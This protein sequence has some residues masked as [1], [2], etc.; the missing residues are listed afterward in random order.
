MHDDSDITQVF[1]SDHGSC[2]TPPDNSGLPDLKHKLLEFGVY[3]DYERYRQKYCAWKD[4]AQSISIADLPSV[5]R[6]EDANIISDPADFQDPYKFQ[7]W[8]PTPQKFHFFFTTSFW[9]AIWNLQAAFLMTF[10]AARRYVPIDLSFDETCLSWID[11]MSTLLWTCSSYFTYLELINLPD[12]GK[13]NFVLPDSWQDV[14]DR[15]GLESFIGSIVPVVAM[16]IWSLGGIAE[17]VP[18]TANS[19]PVQMTDV[20]GGFGFAIVGICEIYHNRR[21]SLRQPFMWAAIVDFLGGWCLVAAAVQVFVASDNQVSQANSLIAGICFIVLAGLELVMWRGNDYGL[22]LLSQLNN[23]IKA[24]HDVAISP[25]T[26]RNVGLAFPPPS[27]QGAVGGDARQMLGSPLG[28]PRRLPQRQQPPPSP[29]ASNSAPVL[30]FSIRGCIFMIVYCWLSS[31]LVINVIR[32]IH[33]YTHTVRRLATVGM[34]VLWILIMGIVFLVHST[35]TSVPNVQPYRAAMFGVRVILFAAAC[36]QT[37]F[38]LA[39]FLESNGHHKH[40]FV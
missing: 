8:F 5:T 19:K 7:Y 24:G 25:G 22:L 35:I 16:V 20:I 4:G 37:M 23:A 34:Q 9:I 29:T 3:G 30:S 33:T 36:F 12:A 28:S 26:G 27:F 6:M 11:L 15:V 39:F 31:C 40:P 2:F 38:L 13:V 1:Q 32:D 17:L 14:R 10:T 18:A 21:S